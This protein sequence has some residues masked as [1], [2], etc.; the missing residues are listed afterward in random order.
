MKKKIFRKYKSKKQHSIDMKKA[1][2]NK[3]LVA[4]IRA[5]QLKD[6]MD[7]IE[8]LEHIRRMRKELAELEDDE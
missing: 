2:G 6:Q 4:E 3:N 7:K 8:M 5:V 1:R